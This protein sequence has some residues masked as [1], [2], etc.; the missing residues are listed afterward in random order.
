MVIAGPK[1]RKLRPPAV[2]MRP[3]R[4]SPILTLRI[5][6]A[7][8]SLLALP[9][10]QAFVL[11]PRHTNPC[12]TSP[13]QSKPSFASNYGEVDAST[14]LL[15]SDIEWRLRPPEG[16]SR[17]ERLKIKLG[18]NILRLESKLK[19][20]TLP[21]VLCPRGGRAVLEAYHSGEN[22]CR[23]QPR[24]TPNQAYY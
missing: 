3:P 22:D 5:V 13:Q 17:L 24:T 2:A 10:S 8:L 1:N 14:H 21:P 19:G 23:T 20:G 4:S 18:A 7:S 6:W 12:I 11:G 9:I 16:T 15:H